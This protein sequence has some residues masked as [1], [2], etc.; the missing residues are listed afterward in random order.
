MHYCK[1]VSFWETVSIEVLCPMLIIGGLPVKSLPRGKF[2]MSQKFVLAYTHTTGAQ[3]SPLPNRLR[4]QTWEVKKSCNQLH[5]LPH[6]IPKVHPFHL[7]PWQFLQ[8]QGNEESLENAL[9][10][11]DFS[12]CKGEYTNQESHINQKKAKS[13]IRP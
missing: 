7:L 6:F 8:C 5:F 11:L 3:C 10:F 4:H 13:S 2:F 9:T 1:G 12:H